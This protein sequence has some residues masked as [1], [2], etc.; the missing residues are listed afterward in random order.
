MLGRF[1]FERISKSVLRLLSTD[2]GETANQYRYLIKKMHVSL[3]IRYRAIRSEQTE[4]R[5]MIILEQSGVKA[6][7]EKTRQIGVEQE[8][9]GERE[10]QCQ[11][12]GENSSENIRAESEKISAEQSGASNVVQIDVQQGEDLILE[13]RQTTAAEYTV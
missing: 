4:L 7:G 12:I 13:G 3:Q 6:S 10:D 8:H 9:H 5:G 1:D 2:R 11:N